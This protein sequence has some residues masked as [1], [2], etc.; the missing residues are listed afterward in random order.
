MSLTLVFSQ[1]VDWWRA[2]VRQAMVNSGV[3]ADICAFLV[4]VSINFGSRDQATRERG[5]ELCRAPDLAGDLGLRLH[6]TLAT[7]VY[8]EDGAEDT[9]KYFETLAKAARNG[10]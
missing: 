9:Y 8:Y 4:T 7:G 3:R 5:L 2:A 10:C 1:R 6:P